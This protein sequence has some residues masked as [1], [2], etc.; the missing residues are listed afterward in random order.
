MQFM[1]FNL[2]FEN[3]R[4]GEKGWL[5][6]RELVVEVIRESS[7]L[8][9]GTQE[10]TQGQLAYLR[11]HLP[12]YQIQASGRF[13]DGTCQYP[14]LF[15][16]AD[17]LR[18][19]DGGEFWLSRTPM[20][21]RSKDWDSAFPRMMNYGLMEDLESRKSLWIAVTHLDHIG[22]DARLQQAEII[23]GWLGNRPEP[24]ILM[25]DFNDVPDSAVHHTLTYPKTGLRDTWQVLGRSEDEASMTH[26]NFSG[27][28][29]QCRMDWI[30]VSREFRVLDAMIVRSQR[31]GFYPSDHFPYA[32]MLTWEKND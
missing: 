16:R 10:G 3:D 17:R 24:Q 15:Y 30:L 14:T 22:T 25:G 13:W 28:P 1:T 18:L 32:A 19:L 2:R 27:V 11:D 4:D 23:A 7:P 26:H 5:C 31:E 29:Q 21:H 20:V 8:V 6:R 12:Q 9:L